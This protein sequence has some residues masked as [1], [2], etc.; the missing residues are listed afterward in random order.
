MPT[1]TKPT[2]TKRPS[3]DELVPADGV[4]IAAIKGKSG[5]DI[6]CELTP[7]HRFSASDM[8][9]LVERIQTRTLNGARGHLQVADRGHSFPNVAVSWIAAVV[10]D[11]KAYIRG[12]VD[13]PEVARWIASGRVDVD[14]IVD[15]GF[16]GLDFLHLGDH[17][18][19]I[20]TPGSAVSVSETGTSSGT[21]NGTTSTGGGDG[22]AGEMRPIGRW[23]GADIPALPVRRRALTPAGEAIGTSTGTTAQQAPASSVGLPSR[24]RQI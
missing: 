23:N 19:K 7:G 9:A 22:S 16:F 20:V 2:T 3:L 11:D 1:A 21:T 8:Q 24:R 14:P 17:P 15:N 5:V 4:D 12:I 18:G 6:L 13:D 10:R